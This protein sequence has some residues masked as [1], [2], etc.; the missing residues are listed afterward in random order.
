MYF[1]F[2]MSIAYLNTFMSETKNIRDFL[3]DRRG[4]DNNVFSDNIG[5]DQ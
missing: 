5:H 1:C 2:C 3:K 4:S